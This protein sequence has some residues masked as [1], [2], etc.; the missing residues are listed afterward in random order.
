MYFLNNRLGPVSAGDVHVLG[1]TLEINMDVGI[2]QRCALMWAP[3]RD[4][5]GC[6]HA[7]PTEMCTDVGIH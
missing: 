5:H 6:G 2:L 3:T 7:H 4:V 1:H